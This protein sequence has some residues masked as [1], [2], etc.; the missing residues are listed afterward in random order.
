M[1]WRGLLIA[2]LLVG[3]AQAD[4]VQELINEGDK[5]LRAE[6]KNQHQVDS[7]AEQSTRL[8]DEF[9]QLS[10]DVNGLEAYQRLLQLQL[11]DQV[12]RVE[13]LNASLQQVAD[14][15]RQILP[16]TERMIST[17][18]EFVDLDMPFLS[19]EREQ[20]L[21]QLESMLV[22]A[23][24]ST[25]EKFRQVMEAYQIENEYGRTIEAYRDDIELNGT[26]HQVSFLRVG[27]VALLYLSDDEQ[28]VGYW[29][30]VENRWKA[31]PQ[32]AARNVRGGLRV[33]RKQV[34][35]AL[36]DVPLVLAQEARQ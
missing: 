21:H 23:D 7:L 30:T 5:R 18:R 27:R 13:D 22:R 4:G 25:A 32:Q 33:A 20:R 12:N 28:F 10:H 6:V 19:I 16:L 29:N 35:P 24:V 31:L 11:Y 15:E 1:T 26:T 36:M 17:L 3:N 9:E 2:M 34:A 14:M 8:V